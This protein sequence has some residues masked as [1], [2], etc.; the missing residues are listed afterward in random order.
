[1]AFRPP[2][3]LRAKTSSGRALRGSSRER[4]G[5]VNSSEILRSLIAAFL[6]D[7]RPS[8]EALA[9]V[10]RDERPRRPESTELYEYRR[11]HRA[12]HSAAGTDYLL[13]TSFEFAS[14]Q[15]TLEELQGILVARLLASSSAFLAEHPGDSL[16]EGSLREIGTILAEPVKGVAVPFLLNVDDIEADRYSINPL[17]ASI[18]ASGQS[19]LPVHRVRGDGL[20]SDP[21]FVAKYLGALVSP[22]DLKEIAEELAGDGGYA[23]FVER[24][25]YRQLARLS[26]ALGV[27]LAIPSYRLPLAPL[28]AE[29]GNGPIH[30]LVRSC[31]RDLSSLREVYSLFGREMG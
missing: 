12:T 5:G 4:R 7:A 23:E 29:S 1:M 18:L 22:L 16:G 11:G 31:H 25:K 14:P 26:E 15:L 8:V 13:R 21:A 10:L 2:R 28:A 24:V 3:Q 9:L 30:D 17:R 27:D 6:R 19:A 20:A